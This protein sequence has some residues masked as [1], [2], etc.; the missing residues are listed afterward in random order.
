MR[1][2]S[3]TVALRYWQNSVAY[4]EAANVLAEKMKETPT[5]LFVPPCLQNLAHGIELLCK[6]ILLDMGKTEK[7]VKDLGHHI[8]AMME[9]TELKELKSLVEELANNWIEND[10]SKREREEF[11]RTMIEATR[12]MTFDYWLEE[13]ERVSSGRGQYAIRYANQETKVP[14]HECLLPIFLAVVYH[15]E[16]T[17]T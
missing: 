16:P 17:R 5:D 11:D 10:L 9:L 1:K 7:E 12:N 2:K 14:P 4:L 13:L 3:I 6:A 15:F 8:K